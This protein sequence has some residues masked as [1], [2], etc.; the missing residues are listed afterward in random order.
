MGATR[1]VQRDIAPAC[2]LSLSSWRLATPGR[3]TIQSRVTIML[4]TKY[5]QNWFITFIFTV[6][7][8]DPRRIWSISKRWLIYFDLMMWW[9]CN[10]EINGK[11]SVG[12]EHVIRAYKRIQRIIKLIK[13]QYCKTKRSLKHKDYNFVSSNKLT[14]K[15]RWLRIS[16]LFWLIS[17]INLLGALVTLRIARLS[18]WSWQS[19]FSNLKWFS[20]STI[21]VLL[22]SFVYCCRY[23]RSIDW[24]LSHDWPHISVL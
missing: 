1:C 18:V 15:I 8:F 16:E 2:Q 4:V 10:D 9:H 21:T 6:Q 3:R 20:G 13:I 14:F 24:L 19:W 11:G 17:P 22:K 5:C 12:Q 23:S 7:W